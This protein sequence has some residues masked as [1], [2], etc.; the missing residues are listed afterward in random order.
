M[1]DTNSFYQLKIL[2]LALVIGVVLFGGVCLVIKLVFSI[3]FPELLP[4]NSIY[5]TILILIVLI[6]GSDFLFK[7]RIS[8]IERG[9]PV[10]EKLAAYRLASLIRFML[11]E[12]AA[13]ISGV[14]YLL[15]GVVLRY[16]VLMIIATGYFIYVKPTKE[17]VIDELNLSYSDQQKLKVT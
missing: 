8:N 5:I 11:I 4:H 15:T 10:K 14:G 13:I 9:M 16:F 7:N 2:H 6:A 12:T 3:S 1:N 17:K